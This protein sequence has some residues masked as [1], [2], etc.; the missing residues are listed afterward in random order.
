LKIPDWV[1]G[2]GGKS[3]TIPLIP[4]LETGSLRTPDTFIAGDVN[5]EGGE[6][7]T[8]ARGRMV[9]TAAET[10]AIFDNIRAA[11]AVNNSLP[12]NMPTPA[13][14]FVSDSDTA[15]IQPMPTPIQ[16]SGSGGVQTIEITY[17]PTIRVDGNVP[18]D[19]EEQLKAHDET[20][21]QKIQDLLRQREDNERRTAYA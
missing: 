15:A 17:S 6:L 7:V 10:S 4:K 5:G 9:F 12:P 8:G 20:L 1:P 19:L 21:L 2:I 13:S 18:G 14:V 16:S 3:I 11:Q